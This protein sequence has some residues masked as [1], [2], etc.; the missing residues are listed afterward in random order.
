M[1]KLKLL[2]LGLASVAILIIITSLYFINDIIY[3]PYTKEESTFVIKPGEG[4]SLINARLANENLISSP[5]AFH[6]Y[7]KFQNKL[8]QFK[9][10]SYKIPKGSSMQEVL[11]ILTEGTPLLK[12]VTIPEGKNMY[13]IAEIMESHNLV[14][15]SE[16]ISLC[17]SKEMIKLIGIDA[18][19]VEGYL[20]PETYMFSP[21]TSAKSIITTM[22]KQFKIQTKNIDLESTNL[23]AHEVVILASIVE[24]ETGAKWERPTIAGVYLNR[25]IFY[26]PPVREY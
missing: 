16:F 7:T 1:K 10:G 11:L 2:L 15:S 6:H 14:D 23:S 8:S 20:F 5:R 21:Q 19:S 25:L 12:K 3:S 18:P 22:I 26:A 13:Q 4:F 24:K 9:I 17:K